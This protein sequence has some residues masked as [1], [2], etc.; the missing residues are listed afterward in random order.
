MTYHLERMV[1][2]GATHYVSVNFDDNTN[3]LINRCGSLEEN[4]QWVIIDLE[5]CF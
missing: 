2:L 4:E 5:D 3:F 1:E